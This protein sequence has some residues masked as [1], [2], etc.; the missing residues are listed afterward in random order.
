MAKIQLLLRDLYSGGICR[1]HIEV[2]CAR[3]CGK[4]K[5]G[6]VCTAEDLR[7]FCEQVNA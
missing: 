4:Q 1:P 2:I 3:C 6:H 5:D 7:R